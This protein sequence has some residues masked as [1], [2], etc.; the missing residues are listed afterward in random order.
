MFAQGRNARLGLLTCTAL[1]PA[2]GCQ[3]GPEAM[4]VSHAAYNETLRRTSGEQLLLNLVRLKYRESPVFLEVGSVSA[5]FVFDRSADLGAT[6]TENVGVSKGNPDILRF[7]GRVGFAERPTI[8]YAPLAGQE[9]V[10]RMLSPIDVETIVMLTQSGWRVDR[11]MRLTIQEANGLD[12]ARTASGPTPGLAPAYK[13]FARVAGL[14]GWMQ[15]RRQVFLEYETRMSDV[16]DPIPPEAITS[17][18]LVK[19]AEAGVRFRRTDDGYVLT[20][21]TSKLLLRFTGGG[22]D[23][24]ESA[25]L[26]ALLSLTPDR[27]AYDLVLARRGGGRSRDDRGLR[28]EIALDTRSLLGVM[29]YLSQAIEAPPEHQAA[30]LITETVDDRG[31]VFDWSAMLGDLIRVQSAKRRPRNAAVAVRHRK[32]WFYIA[33]DDLNSKSTFVLLGQ[34]FT[35]RA[36]GGTGVAPLL[37]LPVG[38]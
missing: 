36:G 32:H 35:L 22:E 28:T 21:Q 20:R 6:V 26:R 37:T 12:N 11:V 38:G 27:S 34:L 9:F 5:Q 7:G 25:E 10:E 31:D 24:E 13:A 1:L 2:V 8:T 14:L 4:R 19:S 3:L 29:F 15:Q 17:D 30:G 16:S 33:D 18:A 23:S